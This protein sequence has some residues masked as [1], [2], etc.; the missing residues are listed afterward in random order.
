MRI[1]RSSATLGRRARRGRRGSRKPGRSSEVRGTEG[2]SSFRSERVPLHGDAGKDR[3][4]LLL[5]L[6][7]GGVA[8]EKLEAVFE[9]EGRPGTTGES[10]DAPVKT[11]GTSPSTRESFRG[12]LL[13]QDRAS[14][15][16]RPRPGAIK[17]PGT[18]HCR[19]GRTTAFACEEECAIR[20]RKDGSTAVSSQARTLVVYNG[21][22][23]NPGISE[24]SGENRMKTRIRKCLHKYPIVMAGMCWI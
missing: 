4:G 18:L 12:A 19:H 13:H 6:E 22:G 2:K 15:Y 11:T 5:F 21:G 16:R 9:D 8:A 20:G 24:Y 10:R 17:S 1:T 3:G 23:N 7:A 14:P